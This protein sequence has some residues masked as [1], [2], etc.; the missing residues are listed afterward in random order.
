MS[1]Y[2]NSVGEGW[3]KNKD[4]IVNEA[5]Y[6][7]NDLACTDN[8]KLMKYEGHKNIL[9]IDLNTMDWDSKEVTEFL[10]KYLKGKNADFYACQDI[11]DTTIQGAKRD[12]SDTVYIAFE[13]KEETVNEDKSSKSMQVFKK[14]NTLNKEIANEIKEV[15]SAKGE[16]PDDKVDD[17]KYGIQEKLSEI[18]DLLQQI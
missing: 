15:L 3:F 14:L 11:I 5:K 12:G 4:N 9:E 10:L 8:L 2:Y 13:S 7:A 17:I 6:T 18:K 16:M 1:V